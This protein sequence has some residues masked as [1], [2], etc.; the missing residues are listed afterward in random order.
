L[1]L[2]RCGRAVSPRLVL[3]RAAL[4]LA[5]PGA[6]GAASARVKTA[7]PCARAEETKQRAL[8]VAAY[9]EQTRWGAARTR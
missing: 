5:A 3:E 2:G 7:A 6:W 8:A 4:P 9:L 1:G